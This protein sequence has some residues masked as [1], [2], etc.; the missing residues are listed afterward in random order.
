MASL[1]DSLVMLD[2]NALTAEFVVVLRLPA[3]DPDRASAALDAALTAEE[4]AAAEQVR[5]LVQAQRREQAELLASR[6]ELIAVQNGKLMRWSQ[7]PRRVY[8]RLRRL[9][10]L[11]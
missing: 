10:R 8:R 7:L 2:P 11:G 3:D 6:Q 1:V 4:D 9:L 5:A